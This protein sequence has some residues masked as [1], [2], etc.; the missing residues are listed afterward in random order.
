MEFGLKTRERCAEWMERGTHTVQDKK[1]KTVK[2]GLHRGMLL[3]SS[4]FRFSGF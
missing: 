3:I 1:W 2:E 4:H